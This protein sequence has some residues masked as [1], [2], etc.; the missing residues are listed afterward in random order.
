[1]SRPFEICDANKL[2]TTTMLSVDSGTGTLAYLFDRNLNLEYQSDGYTGATSTTININFDAPTVVSRIMI[3]NHNLKAF[4]IYYNSA[5]AN[6]FSPDANV[7]ANSAT[8]H[9]FYFNSTTVSSIQIQMDDVIDLNQERSIG[10]LIVTDCT[11]PFEVNPTADNYDPRLYKEK[12]KHTMPDGG[13]SLFIIGNKF[14]AKIKLTF[15]STAFKDNLYDVYVGG[16][17][18]YFI[19]EPTTTAWLGAAVE[20]VWTNDWD[21][22]YAEN[23]KTQGWNGSI[24]IEETP[25]S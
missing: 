5:T 24:V 23:S 15:I 18:F 7:T 22:T 13:T 8:N 11:V 14:Q 3:Q 25:G 12:I 2:N 4:K 10:E 9:Y 6:T 19:P 21:F 17:Q 16:D 20:T 1:M